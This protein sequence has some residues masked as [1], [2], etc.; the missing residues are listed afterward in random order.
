[1]QVGQTH[2]TLCRQTVRGE[3]ARDIEAMREAGVR[4]GFTYPGR[5]PGG[6]FREACGGLFRKR[7]ASRSRRWFRSSEATWAAFAITG[8]TARALCRFGAA[9]VSWLGDTFAGDVLRRLGVSTGTRLLAD[10]YPA[11]ASWKSARGPRPTPRCCGRTVRVHR[12]RGAGGR[13][14]GRKYALVSG[15]VTSTVGPSCEARD[16]LLTQE[17]AAN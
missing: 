4:S 14:P 12:L 17:S 15:V 7:S 6:G 16:V 11:T 13:S 5:S 9:G 2:T 10:R 3:S 8:G 1:M